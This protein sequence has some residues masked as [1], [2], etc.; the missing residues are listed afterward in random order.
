MSFLKIQKIGNA[1]LTLSLLLASCAS[2]G[3]GYAAREELY[4]KLAQ[5]QRPAQPERV[6]RPGVVEKV[7]VAKEEVVPDS[8]VV[9]EPVFS[10]PEVVSAPPKAT[11][12]I[13]SNPMVEAPKV[14]KVKKAKS[15]SK[16][17]VDELDLN[18][19]P[20]TSSPSG[21]GYLLND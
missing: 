14:S 10:E 6:V 4:D 18:I 1:S 16:V 2:R 17:I 5:S 3:P 8:P 13:T 21:Q 12:T 7:A 9:V 11:R 19:V 20:A 15:Y